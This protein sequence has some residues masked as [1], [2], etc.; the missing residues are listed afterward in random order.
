MHSKKPAKYVAIQEWLAN[1][2]ASG[3]FGR[4]ERLPSENQLTEQ[5]NVSRV[6]VRL[7]FDE[8]RSMGLVEAQHG[9]GYFVKK[10]KVEHSLERLMSF[11][12]TIAPLGLETKS[13]VISIV[14]KKADKEIAKPLQLDVGAKV[15]KIVRTRIA[16]GNIV[17]LDISYFPAEIG[18]IL[19]QADLAH[20][21]IFVLL[22]H[23]LNIE[24]GYADV[25]IEFTKLTADHA[26]YLGVEDQSSA[27]R[28]RRLTYDIG[29]KPLD[30]EY[31]YARPDAFQFNARITRY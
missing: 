4:G 28:L 12:E 15:T 9:K 11:G 22:E 18:K 23:E 27:I 31:I 19:A 14:E 25:S 2:I 1:K 26:D 3:E 24:L 29:G 16:G 6:T 13:K 21:D 5:F 20:E 17:S 30:F 10:F 7:A 8:L